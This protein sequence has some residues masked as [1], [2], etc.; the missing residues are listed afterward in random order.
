MGRAQIFKTLKHQP[1]SQRSP[2]FLSTLPWICFLSAL[3]NSDGEFSFF[4]RGL[5]AWN[6]VTTFFL[7][8]SFDYMEWIWSGRI[9]LGWVTTELNFMGNFLLKLDFWLTNHLLFSQVLNPPF[10][11]SLLDCSLKGLEDHR[12]IGRRNVCQLFW[13]WCSCRNSICKKEAT[14]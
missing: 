5:T 7:M 11:E 1:S 3:T 14:N 8:R 4:Q 13:G 6:T 2:F 10:G 12:Q 9:M